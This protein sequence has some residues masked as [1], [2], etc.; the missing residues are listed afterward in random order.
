MTAKSDRAHELGRKAEDIAAE[1]LVSLGWTILERNV[2]NHRGELDIVAIDPKSG[3]NELVVVEVRARSDT[4]TQGPLESIGMRK[5]RT[6][7]R[8]SQ[9]Y[10]ESLGWSGFWRIDVIGITAGSKEAP[11]NWEL[12]HITDITS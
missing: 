4:K 11:D 3:P 7:M 8:S 5:I 1:Y 6:L 10:M 9:E 2:R 12:E